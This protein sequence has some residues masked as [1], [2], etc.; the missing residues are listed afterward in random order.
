[1]TVAANQSLSHPSINQNSLS[2]WWKKGEKKIGENVKLS[3]LRV[4]WRLEQRKSIP[5][6]F[7]A[8]SW[9]DSQ[10]SAPRPK[11]KVV[12]LIRYYPPPTRKYLWYFQKVARSTWLQMRVRVGN[13]VLEILGS[14]NITWTHT[15]VCLHSWHHTIS[16]ACPTRDSTPHSAFAQ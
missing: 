16:N 1:M 2:T 3:P 6:D 8:S 5:L 7:L 10:N 4:V 9:S 15:S 11:Q 13:P 14:K 12:R